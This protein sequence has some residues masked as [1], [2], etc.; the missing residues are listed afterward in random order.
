MPARTAAS[1]LSNG[2]FRN[3][4]FRGAV[5][6]G[7]RLTGGQFSGANFTDVEFNRTDIRGANL[8]GARGLSQDQIG[9]ACGDASTRLPS[10]LTARTCRGITLRIVPPAPPAPPVPP[11]SRNFI[12]ASGN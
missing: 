6:N 9:R 7:A 11:R 10:G 1:N 3:V 5:L 2:D 8:I 4:D 12:I